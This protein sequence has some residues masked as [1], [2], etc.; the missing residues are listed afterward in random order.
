[1]LISS[2]LPFS[3]DY[4]RNHS[5]PSTFRAEAESK[6]RKKWI[7]SGGNYATIS[8]ELMQRVQSSSSRSSKTTASAGAGTGGDIS[9]TTSVASHGTA[10]SHA[11]IMK[12]ELRAMEAENDRLRRRMN[13]LIAQRGPLYDTIG[14]LQEVKRKNDK[15][16]AY[17]HGQER[18]AKQLSDQGARYKSLLASIE[19]LI[20]HYSHMIKEVKMAAHSAKQSKKNSDNG[21]AYLEM[22][23]RDAAEWNEI[24]STSLRTAK[25]RVTDPKK[26]A[27]EALV[28][29]S[30]LSRPCL[31][32]SR[33]RESLAHAVNSI[34]SAAENR[35]SRID[36]PDADTD[37]VMD[38]DLNLSHMSI[39]DA[40]TLPAPMSAPA[41]M[42]PSEETPVRPPHP[43]DVTSSHFLSVRGSIGHSGVR[44]AGARKKNESTLKQRGDITGSRGPGT[45]PGAGSGAV[46]L[47]DAFASTVEFATQCNASVKDASELLTKIESLTADIHRDVSVFETSGARIAV[48]EEVCMARAAAGEVLADV[49]DQQES[50]REK[51]KNLLIRID[52]RINRHGSP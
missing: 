17:V 41:H 47:S 37:N 2:T 35:K 51:V 50:H 28:E 13:D 23:Q 43:H 31:I 3:I 21:R 18:V 10:K 15:M 24:V 27:I 16:R 26:A 29:K 40:S 14:E 46:T 20:E 44:T 36:Q 30:M 45:G 49:C 11:K 1:V 8:S 32:R 6:F 5:L 42:I 12:H 52:D 4:W 19:R 33:G 9:E 48:A 38:S 7:K 22:I 34:I 25:L 39:T